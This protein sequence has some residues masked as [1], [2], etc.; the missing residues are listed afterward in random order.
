M[1]VTLTAAANGTTM[2]GTYTVQAGDAA[3]ADLTVSSYS[4]NSPVT[5]L[6]G[7]TLSGTTM[8]L[9][10][11]NIAA[12]HAIDVDGSRPGTTIS[13][14]K[15]NPAANEIVLTGTK[16]NEIEGYQNGSGVAQDIKAQLNWDKFNWDIDG[17][18]TIKQ[19][20]ILL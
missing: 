3:A 20:L 18:G 16:F 1:N 14:V 9:D 19:A 17:D 7:F 2:T 6:Y 4:I 15:Y 11:A 13:S 5:D 12:N 8:P 10:S